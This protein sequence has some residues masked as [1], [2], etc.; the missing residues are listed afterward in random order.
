MS[1][2]FPVFILELQLLLELLAT[3]F[4]ATELRLCSLEGVCTIRARN[5]TVVH[6]ILM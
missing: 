6:I 1:G 5:K 2:R 4:F 3:E